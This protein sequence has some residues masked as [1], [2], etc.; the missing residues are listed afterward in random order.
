MVLQGGD[1]LFRMISF[2]AMFLPLGAVYSIDKLNQKNKDGKKD[3]SVFSVPVFA[4]LF[5]LVIM[6]VATFFHKTGSEWFPDGTAIYYALSIDQFLTPFGAILYQSPFL[7]QILT[8][9]IYFWWII[10]PILLIFSL[11]AMRTSIIAIFILINIGIGTAMYLGLFPLIVIVTFLAFLPSS[12]WDKR[13]EKM[14]IKQ[15]GTTIYYDGDCGFCKTSVQLIKTFFILPFVNTQ[16]ARENPSIYSDMENYNSWVLEDKRKKRYYK[17]KALLNLLGVSPIF[18]PFKKI[19]SLPVLTRLGNKTYEIVSKNNQRKSCTIPPKPIT[20]K[21]SSKF[22]K[23]LISVFLIFIILYILFW[24][25]DDIT[26][27][28][29]IKH[30]HNWIG[31]MLHIDQRWNMFSPRLL[32]DDGW[33]IIDA[34]LRDGT[35]F[36]LFNTN[37]PIDWEKPELVAHTYKNQRWRKYMMNL[38]LKKNKE[39]RL[40][41]GKY[42]CRNWNKNR[43]YDKQLKEFEIIFMREDTLLNYEYTKP[44]KIVLWSHKCF[45]ED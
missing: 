10:G 32:T 9:F 44:E 25:I 6:Y 12:F 11:K 36:D 27:T 29:I 7:M 24:N 1:V 28:D 37:Q 23:I 2:F 3:F 19:F 45:K 43:D 16:P 13:K 17:F 15:E 21:S 22:I 33:Y 31:R 39:H 26:Y 34:D 41:Y 30:E 35:N 5:Q 14:R 38:W 4:L 40:Y 20:K 8:Y 42:L 18:W